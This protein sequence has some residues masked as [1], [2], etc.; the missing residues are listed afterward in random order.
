MSYT[1]IKERNGKKYYYRVLSVRRGEKVSKTRRYLG[2]NLT[3][4]DR[5]LK[6]NEA[7]KNLNSIIKAK[8]MKILKKLMPKIIKILKKYNI[9]KQEYL[10]AM[11]K[12]K[13]EKTVT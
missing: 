10:E 5:L 1:E 8:K 7:D 3:K 4:E 13:Q 2:V 9:K 12:E 6:E 11:L